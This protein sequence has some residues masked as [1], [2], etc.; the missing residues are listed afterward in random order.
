MRMTKR[1][2]SA[3]VGFEKCKLGPYSAM[4]WNTRWDCA[5]LHIALVS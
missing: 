4:K 3:F 2:R 5:P 1:Y